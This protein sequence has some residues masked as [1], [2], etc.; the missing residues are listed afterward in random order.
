[1]I[2]KLTIATALMVALAATACS[3]M[4]SW[5]G[6]DATGA[7]GMSGESYVGTPEDPAGTA[8]SGTGS[9]ST[10]AQMREAA[11]SGEGLD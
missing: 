2:S 1:M 7:T 6:G 11:A 4:P 3:G 8:N 9:G 10:I 5:M